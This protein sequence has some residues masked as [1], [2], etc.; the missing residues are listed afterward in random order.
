MISSFFITLS[1][2]FHEVFVAQWNWWMVLGL[3]G[4]ICFTMRFVVQWLASEIAKKSVVPVAFWFFSLIGGG[5]L[6]IY[7]IYLKNPVFIL[8]NSLGFSVYLRNI[9]L[10]YREHNQSRVKTVI[11]S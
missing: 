4:Q 3:V 1:D 9:W 8:G 5:L 2:W 10:I 7:S 11:S 6:L